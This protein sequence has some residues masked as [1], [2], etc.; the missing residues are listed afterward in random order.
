M[1]KKIQLKTAKNSGSVTEFIK[2]IEDESL[3]KD[4]KTLLKLFKETTGLRPK[5]WGNSI[6]GFGEY[7]YFR[8]NGDE[9]QFMATG[10]SPRKSGPTLYIMPGYQGYAKVLEKLGPH[11]L[12]KSCLYIKRVSD[13]DTSILKKIIKDG[14]K[15]LK[16]SH[17]TNY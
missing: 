6:I 11:K 4:C 13:I 7:T 8:S 12:G 2:N 10:F 16:K 5:M 3:R 15:D 1:A 14:L 9:G 17:K